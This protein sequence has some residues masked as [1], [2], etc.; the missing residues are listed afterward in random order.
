MLPRSPLDLPEKALL[1]GA[2]GT[3]LERRGVRT[4][5]P[6][7]SA[8]A[9]REAPDLLLQIHTEYV[10]AGADILTACTF[11]TSRYT[12]SKLGRSDEAQALSLEAVELARRACITSSR[13]V[14]IAGSIAPLEDCYHPERTQ[15]LPVLEREHAA[16]AEALA[17]AGVDLLLV[18]TMPTAIEAISAA[19]AASRTGVPFA[20]S[21]LPGPDAT[22]FDGTA[23]AD[24]AGRVARESPALMCVNCGPVSWCDAALETLARTGIPFGLYANS[25]TPD[26][27]FGG[28]PAPLDVLRYAEQASSW[29]HRGARVVGGCCGTTPAHIAALREVVDR[30]GS[31]GS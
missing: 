31:A 23:L 20:V 26:R 2:T 22:L 19:R 24:A 4:S 3:E 15:P 9:V 30:P 17:A 16:H 8:A 14:L 7:W 18:E 28:T 12:L 11:R 27:S 10:A 13:R 6:L 21:L 1:D 25:G 5:L 29:F